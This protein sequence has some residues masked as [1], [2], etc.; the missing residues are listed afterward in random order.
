MVA[1]VLV[2]VAIVAVAGWMLYRVLAPARAIWRGDARRVPSFSQITVNARSYLAFLLWF[3]PMFV[4]IALLG[5]MLIWI[6]IT[7]EVSTAGRAIATTGVALVVVGLPLIV[8]RWVVSAFGRPRFLVPPPYRGQ[9]AGLAEARER[10]RR[11]REGTPPTDHVVEILDVR[12][13]PP[14]TSYEPYLMALCSEPGCDWMEFPDDKLIGAPE[15]D[16]LRRLAAEHSTTV[17]PGL[18]RPLG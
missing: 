17:A 13:L 18:V 9:R 14:D 10:R 2:G 5:I 6:S 16:Q 11:K 15:E 7:G 3:V 12:P 4:G 1:G 8:L